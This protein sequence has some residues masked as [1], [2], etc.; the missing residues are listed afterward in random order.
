MEGSWNL[1][2]AILVL[3]PL[4]CIWW[5]YCLL[6]A[7]RL[8]YQT[9]HL[10]RTRSSSMQALLV[11]VALWG[12]ALSMRIAETQLQTRYYE[13]TVEVLFD[14][15]L[16]L[17]FGICTGIVCRGDGYIWITP[18]INQGRAGWLTQYA[19]LHTIPA[20]DKPKFGWKAWFWSGLSLAVLIFTLPALYYGTTL[21][22][23]NVLR[24]GVA[25]EMAI[26]AGIADAGGDYANGLRRLYEIPAAGE[27]NESIHYS[28]RNQGEYE[29]WLYTWTD[30]ID[31]PGRKYIEAY[32]DAYNNA[33]QNNC[34]DSNVSPAGRNK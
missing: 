9:E 21:L 17:S 32:V 2:N 33:M 4:L 14:L 20:P 15:S 25:K 26:R 16:A 3:Q 8:P 22:G 6:S 30:E 10:Q 7:S 27:R 18:F 31:N 1:G 13:S 29:V 19:T 11:F 28:G 24:E 5:G 34:G 12:V 23:D